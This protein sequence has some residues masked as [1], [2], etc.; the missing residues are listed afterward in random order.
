MGAKKIT[1]ALAGNPNVGKS[2]VFNSLTGLCQHTGN[3]T[4][5]TV[6][7]TS[8][9]CSYNGINY[10]LYDLPGTY[11]ILSNSAEEEL[12][13]DFIAFGD[14]DGIVVV[15]DATALERG[16]ILLFQIMEIT[17][18]VVLCVNLI[19]EAARKKISVDCEKLENL[20]GIPVVP[21][22]AHKKQDVNKLL[23]AFEMQRTKNTCPRI[24]LTYNDTIENA[25]KE[26]HSP[27]SQLF[28]TH[29]IKLCPRFAALRI[30]GSEEK[31]I[32]SLE[33]YLK[34]DILS[35]TT[36]KTPL[37]NAQKILSDAEISSECLNSSLA[38]A[39]IK[40][41]EQTAK[42]A[43]SYN[44][45]N[46]LSRDRKIDKILT[47]KKFGLPIML[48]LLGIVFFIT[49]QLS[50]YPSDFLAFIF[51]RLE[52]PLNSFLKLLNTPW[53]FQQP[54]MDGVYKTTAWVIA[55]MLPP[56][57]IFFPLFTLLEDFG[58]LPRVAFNLDNAL[59][60]CGCSG[61]QSLSM[62]MDTRTK[63]TPHNYITKAVLNF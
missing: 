22:S 35:D 34:I 33:K 47:S 40:K 48:L 4:G 58:Y 49:I 26:L 63:K 2:T 38:C 41:A 46:Y 39:L 21:T 62:C 59:K 30:L 42:E 32:H 7:I 20:L 28:D 6:D 18:N 25:V 43:V 45:P 13:R 17:H 54:L 14:A 12:A 61:K 56:M 51:N 19:D 37:V 5:K 44:N 15:T 23:S 57:A 36:I 24:H 1:L 8:G 27:L 31:I 3:W 9:S 29:S 10:T 52:K 55:V 11:S 53:W 60:K 50:N 16:L